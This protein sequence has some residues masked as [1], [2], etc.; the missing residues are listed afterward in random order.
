MFKSR[1]G[2][3]VSSSFATN[4]AL[5]AGTNVTM[6][7]LAM[8]SAILA[9]RL[10]G[11][12]GRGELAAIQ[13]W[14]SFIATIATLGMIEATVYYSARDPE[15][16]GHYIGSGS[17]IA[18]I[19][20]IP[21]LLGGYLA[22]PA[23]LAAQPGEIVGAARWYLLIAPIYALVALP[24]HSLRGRGD[25]VA[26]NA[27]RLS[28]NLVWVG[29]L[30]V[31]WMI[32][33]RSASIL[34][35]VFL[36]LQALMFLPFS[37]VVARR[38][39]GSFEPAIQD[40]RKM[41]RYGIPCMMTSLPQ[42]LNFRLDQMLM[43]ALLPAVALGEYAVAVAWSG[44]IAPILNAIGS[45]LL[46][47]VA[48]S[49]SH[50]EGARKF[51]RGVRAAALFALGA[52]LSLMAITPVALVTLFGPSFRTAVPAA[53][54]L[55]PAASLLGLNSVLEEG[56][57]GLGHPYPV[58]HAELA[59]L[60]T[61]GLVLVLTLKPMG[62]MGA[63]ISS[64]AGYSTVTLGLLLSARRYAGASPASLLWPQAGELKLGLRRLVYLAR[65]P[66]A[67]SD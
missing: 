61:T 54:V 55:A 51:A 41:V 31:A 6:A 21:F 32:A 2:A 15:R 26:W 20:A 42:N 29:E 53:L 23:C 16:T 30:I 58:L 35:E 27:L 48:S 64:L 45:A 62:I 22:M 36:M 57:R 65:I 9:A 60:A 10:L 50:E 34:A 63:A 25:F 13:A 3:G 18:L 37:Y 49:E 28:P 66:A 38:V 14:P 33:V 43:A 52:C 12:K 11:P 44:A 19:A 40:W 24:A 17:I 39:P 1:R 67:P 8:G 59:G 56:L 46:H 5:T 47:S 4:A 7:A